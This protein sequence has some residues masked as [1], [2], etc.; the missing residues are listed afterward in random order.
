MADAL[1]G[2][3]GFVGSTLMKQRTFDAFYRSTNIE[4]IRGQEFD[5]VVCAGAPAQK[6]LANKDPDGDR[7]K[8][9]SLIQC[10]ESIKCKRFILISTVDVFKNPNGVDERCV[11]ELNGLHAYGANRFYLEEFVREKYANHLVV[12][13]PGLVG[14]GLRKNII[15]DLLNCN[16]IGKIDS[17]AVFQFYPMVNLWLDIEKALE[18]KLELVHLTAEPVSVR[19]IA[20][21]GFNIEF[22]A[23][24]DATPPCYNMKTLYAD[25]FGGRD[26]YQYSSR[27]TILA[28]RSYAQSAEKSEHKG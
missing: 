20:K 16:D 7:L 12:R 2:F 24:L 8:I 25:S 26:G 27:D 11:I 19:N 13:L 9:E 14:P 5:T 17:R 18:E 4:D 1:I 23:V 21:Y 28:V 6:W 10:L 22:T 3:S 15:Y